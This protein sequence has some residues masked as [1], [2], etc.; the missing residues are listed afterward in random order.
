M[1]AA[2]YFIGAIIVFIIGVISIFGWI[3]MKGRDE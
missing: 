2:L 1:N 3:D